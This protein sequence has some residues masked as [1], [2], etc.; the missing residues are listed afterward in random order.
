[1][2]EIFIGLKRMSRLIYIASYEVILKIV[3]QSK[4][5][6]DPDFFWLVL[7]NAMCFYFSQTEIPSFF[8]YDCSFFCSPP[9]ST[10]ELQE[11][12][13]TELLPFGIFDHLKDAVT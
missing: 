7:S 13:L 10:P 1:M 12:T 2:C 9:H 4:N 3:F 5:M 8:E 11:S 6:Q